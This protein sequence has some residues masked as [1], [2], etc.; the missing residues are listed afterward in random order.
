[1]Q[2]ISKSQRRGLVMLAIS[3]VVLL[4]LIVL[5]AARLAA[6]NAQVSKVP[7]FTL[8]GKPAPDFTTM[9]YNGASGQRIHLA[10]LKGR[11]VVINFFASWCVPCVEEAPIL[12]ASAK[13]YAPQGVAFIGIVYQDTQVNSLDFAQQYGLSYAIGS[14]PGGTT[15]IAYGVTGVPET[16]FINR[17]GVVVSK[18]FSASDSASFDRAIQAILR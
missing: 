16:V 10:A 11:P 4:G 14:D 3:A 2:A 7:S 5:L 13:K 1:M 17:Q 9:L 18:I 6:A 12:S 8:D 15:A